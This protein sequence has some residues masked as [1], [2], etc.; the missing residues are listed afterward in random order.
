[1]LRLV[2]QPVLSDSRFVV[3]KVMLR[4]ADLPALM[5]AP[6]ER[7]VM[8]PVVQFVKDW[9]NSPGDARVTL[10][11]SAPVGSD[12]KLLATV[13]AIVHA[14]ADRDGIAVPGWVNRHVVSPMSIS[15][16]DL[17]SDYGKLLVKNTPAVAVDHGVFFDREL[18]TR[19]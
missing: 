8:T 17:S 18:L 10:V 15:G 9:N 13:A 14:L 11:Q 3:M 19:R 5:S 4:A 16:I 6:D 2:I 1:M 7:G 12:E